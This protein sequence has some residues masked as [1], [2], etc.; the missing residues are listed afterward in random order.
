M[1][2][3]TFLLRQS[4]VLFLYA[5]FKT[6]NCKI[7][8]ISKVLTN[9]LLFYHSRIIH[10]PIMAAQL[11]LRISLEGGRVTKTIQFDPNTSVFDACRIIRD[12]FADA[13]QGQ[14]EFLVFLNWQIN[15]LSFLFNSHW[16]WFV[17][18]GRRQSPRRL[19]GTRPQSRLL[20]VAQPRRSR[21][22]PQTENI[23]RE[24][25]RR[26][27]ENNPRWW[28]TAGLAIDGCHLHKDW[29]H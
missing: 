10:W 17:L 3:T 12:K 25:A 28:L 22:P 2:C 15:W 9:F 24:N 11:S 13:V 1:N 21:V 8:K 5:T 6:V 4:T 29:H 7:Q 16:I 26:S 19:A 27:C 23:A 18:V 20:H 14:G